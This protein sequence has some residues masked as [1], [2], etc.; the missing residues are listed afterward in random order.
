[1]AIEPKLEQDNFYAPGVQDFT[2]ETR[3]WG[4]IFRVAIDQWVRNNLNVSIPGRIT[5]VQNNSFVDVQPLIQEIFKVQG[6]I[7]VPELLNIPVEHPRGADY[8]VKLPIAVGDYGRINFCD[9]S[10]DNWLVSGGGP[11]N[12]DDTRMHHLSDATFTPGLYPQN[13]ILP[14]DPTDMILHNGDAEIYL[15]KDGKF[16]IT[17]GVTELISLLSQLTELLSTA[18]TVLG[19]P[20]VPAVVAQLE[21]ITENIETLQ[22]E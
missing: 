1:M 11:L 7:S 2:P 10:L 21:Q 14:G 9:R 18:S 8:W 5:R 16:K 17:N 15:Q 12:P 3:S 13:D 6:P 4:E 22:G 20:F 19:G